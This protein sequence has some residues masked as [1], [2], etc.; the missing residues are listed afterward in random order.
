M[1]LL[2]LDDDV[3]LNISCA[4]NGTVTLYWNIRQSTYVNSQVEYKCF[5]NQNYE[6]Y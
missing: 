2:D 4:I 1:Y 6:V 5:C 3:M